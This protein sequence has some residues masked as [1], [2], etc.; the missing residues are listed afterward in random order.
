MCQHPVINHLLIL[1]PADDAIEAIK[2]S[3]CYEQDVGGVNL[4]SFTSQFPRVLLRN[5]NNSA[6]Q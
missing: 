3:R 5:I 1:S 4:D 2:R 6:F